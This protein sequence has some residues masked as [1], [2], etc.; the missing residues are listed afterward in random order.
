MQVSSSGL[1][2][3]VFP[4]RGNW[5]SLLWSAFNYF[6]YKHCKDESIIHTP[7]P[8]PLQY[9]ADSLEYSVCFKIVLPLDCI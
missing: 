7:L 9:V 2:G 8:A 1:S 4:S 5:L 6:C 3:L